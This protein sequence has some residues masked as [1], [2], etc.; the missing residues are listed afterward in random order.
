MSTESI[1][2][3]AVYT[4]KSSEEGLEQSFNSLDAQREACEAFICS[5]RQEGWRV[6]PARYDDGGYSGGN[7]ERPALQRLLEHVEANRVNVIVVY[8]VD[9]LTRSLADFAKIVEALDARGVSFV[10]V[11]Q[12]FNTTSSMG[13]LT[14]NVLLS[15]AQFERE[16]T[17]E[18]IRDKIAASKKKG[19]WM[20]G[21]VPLGYDLQS[22]KL[23]PNHKEA[24]LVRK[25]FT[26]YLKVGCV[27]K[28][29]IQLRRE[30]IK[31]KSWT[32]RTGS[33]RGD[34][35]FARGALY[36]L[37]RNRLYIGEIGHRGQWYAGEHEGILP[38]ELWDRVQRQLSQNLETRHTRIGQQ[39]SSL[40]T[41]LME[42]A[43]GN[44][45]TPSFTVKSGRRYRYYV[46]QI[47]IENPGTRGQGPTRLPAEEVETRVTEMLCSFLS[48]DARVFDELS[49]ASESAD[50]LHRLIAAASTLASRWKNGHD[51]ELR[52]MLSSFVRRV[53]VGENEIQILISRTDLRHLLDLDKIT[54]SG[55]ERWQGSAKANDLVC[56]TLEAKLKR[57]GGEIHLIV[58]PNSSAAMSPKQS[59]PALVKAVARAYGW[60]ERILEG[61]AL[62]QRSLARHSGLTER[63][64]G[65]VLKCA[66]LAPDIVEAILDG[67]Q[68]LD[69]NFEKLSKQI[70]LSW[71]EQRQRFGFRSL[72]LR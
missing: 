1:L 60:Y 70:P 6:L 55:R 21:P 16:V 30:K 3:C 5:Q 47:A 7:M 37:L 65:K 64:V 61:K 45:F 8:K 53:V 39:S 42:D 59:K 25:I 48:A 72:P 56:L 4:R 19:I 54:S 12:Q 17:S 36:D 35:S 58:P 69:L 2:H 67:R 31:S 20:G 57:C 44:R 18:R 40:L 24:T 23:V 51:A 26:L 46:S 13:R 10:S 33:H 27:S 14:L 38:Q 22:R 29:A 34:V 52:K 68:P 63:Y 15:F 11:T 32:T 49:L 50:D 41:G 71:V 62:D 28:L 43:N 66:F 9:R